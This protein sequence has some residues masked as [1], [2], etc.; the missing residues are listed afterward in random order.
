[1]GKVKNREF[2]QSATM[3]NYTF[4]QYYNRLTELSMSM[5]EWKNLPETVDERFLELVL[6]ADGMAIFF[7]DEEIGYLGLRTMIGGHLNVYQ[8]P[9]QRTAYA[10]NGYN[11]MLDEKDSVIIFNNLLHTNSLLDI[12]QFSKRLYNLDRTIDVNTNAQKTPIL[13]TCEESQRLTMQNLYMKYDGNQPVIFSDKSLNPNALKVLNTGAPYVADKLYSLKVQIWNEALTYLGIPNIN[14][15]K[16]E[17]MIS[18][19]VQRNQGGIIASRYSRLNARR[20]A[21]EQ[22]NEMFG[23]NIEVN[24]RDEFKSDEDLKIL[25][26]KTED[27][28]YNKEGGDNE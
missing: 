13:I 1:M 27:I 6:F 20:Q 11:K 2:W 21:A 18:D 28:S 9:T 7:K 8:I 24:Y 3:N 17:R 16:K 22:I 19:E 26:D 23:L 25:L 14:Y 12:E 10:S 4:M 5:F 15:Q